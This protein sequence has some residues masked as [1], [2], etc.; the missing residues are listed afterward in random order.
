MPSKFGQR[1]EIDVAPLH[2]HSNLEGSMKLTAQVESVR[3]L[4]YSVDSPVNWKRSCS[5]G[6]SRPFRK[7]SEFKSGKRLNWTSDRTCS[8]NW[9]HRRRNSAR[10][11]SRTGLK[12]SI[13][14][15]R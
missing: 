7:Q 9:S 12:S 6:L 14:V 2:T 3:F 4:E 13:S 15:S 8:S 5:R 10:P 11:K 1:V